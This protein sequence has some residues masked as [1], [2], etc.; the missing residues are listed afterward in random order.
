MGTTSTGVGHED[1]SSSSEN[2][3]SDPLANFTK[4][5]YNPFKSVEKPQASAPQGM[6]SAG[7]Y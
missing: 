1:V 3:S 6:D 4:P 7:H 2:K 5:T